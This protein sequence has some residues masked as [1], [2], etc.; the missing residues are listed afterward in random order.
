MIT[1]TRDKFLQ[2]FPKAAEGFNNWMMNYGIR[3]LIE[4]DHLC[5]KC[6]TKKEFEDIRSYMA[7]HQIFWLGHEDAII[8]DRKI[9]TGTWKHGYEHFEPQTIAGP[10]RCLELADQKPNHSQKSGFDHIEFLPKGITVD[11]LI[12]VLESKGMRV[13]KEERPHH[14][15]WNITDPKNFW[16]DV[17]FKI[18]EKSLTEKVKEE[19]KNNN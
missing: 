7:E 10:I 2:D 15:T 11:G 5:Y 18:S 4:P 3:S 9:A 16:G 13:E 12:K 19:I 6:S 8:S 17:K 1:T 14:T